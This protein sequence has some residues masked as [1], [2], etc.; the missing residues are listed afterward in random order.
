MIVVVIRLSPIYYIPAV[1]ER[2]SSPSQSFP[3]RPVIYYFISP[4]S[5]SDFKGGLLLLLYA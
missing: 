2:K 1:S 3:D 4:L 5:H